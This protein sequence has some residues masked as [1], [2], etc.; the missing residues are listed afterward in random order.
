[1]SMRTR[2]KNGRK[3][4]HLERKAAEVQQ[5]GLHDELH[6]RDTRLDLL[7]HVILEFRLGQSR[8]V[9]LLLKVLLQ[10]QRGGEAT[11]RVLG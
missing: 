7:A 6:H 1:M 9:D 8:R 11:E 3:K 4:N 5:D 2:V 10:Q